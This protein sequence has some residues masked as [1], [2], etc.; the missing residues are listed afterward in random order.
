[1]LQFFR[2]KNEENKRHKTLH[3]TYQPTICKCY[4]LRSCQVISK[5][6]IFFFQDFDAR[7]RE[8]TRHMLRHCVSVL[9]LRVEN[10]L[11]KK[12]CNNSDIKPRMNATS[13]LFA[14]QFSLLTLVCFVLLLVFLLFQSN[15]IIATCV[16]AFF[17]DQI[18]QHT[19][20]TLALFLSSSR[21]NT[22]A[23]SLPLL[24]VSSKFFF[25]FHYFFLLS[26]DDGTVIVDRRRR[27]LK[28]QHFVNKN[29]ISFNSSATK[30]LSMFIRLKLR[31]L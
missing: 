4:I 29:A 5:I 25:H 18:Y 11:T 26:I 6:K 7:I 13:L 19:C 9:F 12:K 3:T 14:Q 15:T 31:G 10:I 30:S 20:A 1:M 16:M 17:N 8:R 24:N 21:I 23:R 28:R 22:F 2:A 27:K